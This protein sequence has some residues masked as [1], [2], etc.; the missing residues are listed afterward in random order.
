MALIW[1]LVVGV[2]AYLRWP[3]QFWA[4]VG[5]ILGVV[6]LDIWW[7]TRRAEEADN[8]PAENVGEAGDSSGGTN[9]TGGGFND[10][11]W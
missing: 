6:H 9:N 2:G 10:G 7:A 11:I 3:W 4:G 1:V 8:L 5:M